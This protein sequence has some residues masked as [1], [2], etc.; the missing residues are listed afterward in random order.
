VVVDHD[1]GELTVRCIESLRKTVWDGELEIVLVDNA[2][3]SPIETPWPEVRVRREASNRGFAGG[4]NA[5]IGNLDGI[6]AVAL[7][8]NDAV[9]D[10]GW[11]VPLARAL[12]ADASLGAC[13]P[14]IRF[15][16][17]PIINNVGTILRHDWYGLDRG[18]EEPDVG[19]YD[20]AEEIEAWCGGAVLLRSGY[21]ASCGL[22]DERLF[23]YYEDLELAIRG[24]KAGWRYHLAP[25][26]V[27]DH[28]HSATAVSGSD[29]S[30]YYKER[31]RLL[32][33]ALHAPIHLVV[34]LPLRHVI[35]T[36][37]YASH[38]EWHVVRLRSRAFAGWLR[39]LP[40]M[41]RTRRSRATGH[42][43]RRVNLQ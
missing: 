27:V 43:N 12:D 21:L 17:V 18:Y 14:K 39:L 37:S 4:A 34:W 20:R 11:L 40:A 33:V 9:V 13:S 3:R 6:D 5:G 28:E 15:M 29:F 1:G 26:S 36:A 42:T 30:E 7:V 32:V 22:F 41:L 23:L 2:S 38:G 25:E 31:N 10:P 19:Q 24:R 35:A 16:G 8:N